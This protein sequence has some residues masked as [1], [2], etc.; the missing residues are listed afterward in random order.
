M[1]EGAEHLT[2]MMQESLA[3]VPA[4]RHQLIESVPKRGTENGQIVYCAAKHSSETPQIPQA[5][6]ESLT[7]GSS[8]DRVR[9][10]RE[11]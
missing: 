3:G 4:S 6:K 7:T 1:K 5:V 9:T 11:T 2:L 10:A 8:P